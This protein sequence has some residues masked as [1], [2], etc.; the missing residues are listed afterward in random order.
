M[1]TL[2]YLKRLGLHGGM[3]V[4][5]V[6]LILGAFVLELLSLLELEKRAHDGD[7]DPPH[8]VHSDGTPWPENTAHEQWD[9]YYGDR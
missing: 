5:R 8:G 7:D 9:V 1:K 3:L 2:K 4:W 6:L